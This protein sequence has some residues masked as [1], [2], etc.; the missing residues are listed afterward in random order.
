MGWIP[1][2]IGALCCIMLGRKAA[3]TIRERE[4][5]LDQWHQAMI[6][7]E[8][9]IEGGGLPL[10]GLLEAGGIPWLAQAAKLLRENPALSPAE[11]LAAFPPEAHFTLP[12][13]EVIDDLI[14]GLFSPDR[15]RQLQAV[16]HGEEQWR[17]FLQRYRMKAE[18]N[19]RLYQSLGWLSGAA[20][21][22]LL[23]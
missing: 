14:I 19:I 10:P 5:C 21:F 7:M 23:C 11:M 3:V 16:R 12:E 8:S 13:R 1:A 6:R 18:K 22:I 20:A 15:Q 2:L 4:K 9:T 17:Y